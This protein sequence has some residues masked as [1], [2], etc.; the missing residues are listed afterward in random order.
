MAAL[1]GRLNRGELRDAPEQ[2]G[3]A[4]N[5]ASTLA[6]GLARSTPPNAELL[7]N[8][9]AA[10]SAALSSLRGRVAEIT[11][12]D[13][14]GRVATAVL[15][16][17]RMSAKDREAW[18]VGWRKWTAAKD[19][20]LAENE[21]RTKPGEVPAAGDWA[22]PE[23]EKAARRARVAIDLGRLGGQSL[24]ALQSETVEIASRSDVAA[25]N[26]FAPKLLKVF[27]AP[28]AGDVFVADRTGRVFG[29]T[30]A[31]AQLSA[32]VRKE[33]WTWSAERYESEARSR[34]LG[35]LP[36]YLKAVQDARAAADV[37]RNA[38]GP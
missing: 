26:G 21:E 27:A 18:W 5:A 12:R 14:D 19:Q 17:P 7:N 8:Q 9:T 4:V 15:A 1:F 28:V 32:R 33:F 25:W 16:T 35:R 37:A 22:G 20:W 24:D 31:S 10:L 6:D 38:S 2:W 13:P 34:G 11:K 30:D 29:T 23:A 36:F 3:N